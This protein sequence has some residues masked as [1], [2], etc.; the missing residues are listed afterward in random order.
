MIGLLF[1]ARLRSLGFST[2]LSRGADPSGLLK[3]ET[4]A[5]AQ[6]HTRWASFSIPVGVM[7]IC[8]VRQVVIP[9]H[10]EHVAAIL[11]ASVHREGMWFFRLV[12]VAVLFACL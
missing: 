11:T 1:T 6:I 5:A 3:R 4:F 2:R 9:F 8:P 7:L 12:R 10:H